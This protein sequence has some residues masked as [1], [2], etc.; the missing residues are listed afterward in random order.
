MSFSAKYWFERL[1]D[2]TKGKFTS[3]RLEGVRRA[4]LILEHYDSVGLLI[5]GTAKAVWAGI[6]ENPDFESYR[7]SDV[8]VLIL[9]YDCKHHPHNFEGGV[10]WFIRHSAEDL[11]NN[12]K[13]CLD[14][15]LH[16]NKDVERHP[17]LYLCHWSILQQTDRYLFDVLRTELDTL[18]KKPCWRD[19]EVVYPDDSLAP[20][21]VIGSSDLEFVPSFGGPKNTYCKPLLMK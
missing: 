6:Y 5:G 15:N 14:Y 4:F 20:M 12:G 17:G 2:K 8:D 9:D 21:A 19:F 1:K 16:L 11:P 18:G 10:D 7:A 3:L 13:F